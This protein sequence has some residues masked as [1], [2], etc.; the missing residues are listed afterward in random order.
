MVDQGEEVKRRQTLGFFRRRL[1]VD[2][3]KATSE[4]PWEIEFPARECVA[5]AC[6][7]PMYR[8]SSRR[9]L[10]VLVYAKLCRDIRDRGR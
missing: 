10:V 4:R 6:G 3:A 5:V 8:E 7:I 9:T 2:E 1:H